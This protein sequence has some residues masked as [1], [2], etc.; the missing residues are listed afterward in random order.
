MD[1][2]RK[3]ADLEVPDP[4]KFVRRNK[5]FPAVHIRNLTPDQIRALGELFIEK[6][7]KMAEDARKKGPLADLGL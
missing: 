4:P 7:L 2:T 6:W 3:I 1:K 5:G